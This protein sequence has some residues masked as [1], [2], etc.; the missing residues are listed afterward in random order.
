MKVTLPDDFSEI[1]V[2]QY[3]KLWAMYEKENDAYNAQRRCIELLAGL[4]PNALQDATWD[5]IER[6][7]ATLNWL[8]ED[9]D[10]FT[11]KMPLVRRFE[12]KG[13]QYGF[14][15][16]LSKLTVGEYADLETMCSGGVFKSL[17]KLC[18]ILFR[19]VIDEKLDKY[20]IANYRISK[21]RK[22]A[23]LDLPMNIAIGAV[24]FFCNTAKELISTTQHYLE[25][26][27]AKVKAMQST[28]NGAGSGLSMKWLKAIFL[29]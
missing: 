4:E 7:S 22:E 27:K 8:M 16:D 20:E 17:E 15:P 10:P 29:K 1:T 26:E 12:L 28:K 9:P 18:A 14:I 5:S 19:E 3:M 23:M 25:K 24:V 11:R 21:E 13:Q 6:A 2:G